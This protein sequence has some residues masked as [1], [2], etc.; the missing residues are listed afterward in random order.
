MTVKPPAAPPL[1]DE[2]DRLPRRCG[3]RLAASPRPR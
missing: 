1:A 3:C 2:L